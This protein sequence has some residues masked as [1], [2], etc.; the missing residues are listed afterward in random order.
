[1]ERFEESL[2]ILADLLEL[3]KLPRPSGRKFVSQWEKVDQNRKED[4]LAL[5]KRNLC[6]TEVYRQHLDRHEALVRCKGAPFQA[7]L[8]DYYAGKAFVGD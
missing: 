8:E 1:M 3:K 4:M 5:Q 7:L 2:V 6:S